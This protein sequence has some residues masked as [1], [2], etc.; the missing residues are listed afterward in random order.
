M[1]PLNKDLKLIGK[2]FKFLNFP[3]LILKCLR[4]C[5]SYRVSM[6]KARCITHQGKVISATGVHNHPPHTKH[7]SD[8]H[9]YNQMSHSPNEF[10]NQPIPTTS[11]H[12]PQLMPPYQHYLQ[13]SMAPNQIPFP[14][15]QNPRSPNMSSQ[16]ISPSGNFKMENI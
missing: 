12:Q 4:L 8:S 11:S 6:C 13:H 7:K 10:F 9:P 15:I 3:F 5:K 2:D 14:P 16:N 1:S